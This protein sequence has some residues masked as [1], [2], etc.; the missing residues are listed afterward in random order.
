MGIPLRCFGTRRIDCEYAGRGFLGP[1][2]SPALSPRPTLASRPLFLV[3]ERFIGDRGQGARGKDRFEGFCERKAEL[4][5][6]FLK[7]RM[8][9]VAK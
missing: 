5:H 2:A 9:K 7:E 6:S 8:P 3:L 1:S 4:I